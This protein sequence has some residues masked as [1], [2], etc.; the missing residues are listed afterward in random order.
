MAAAAKRADRLP[1]FFALLRDNL[2]T[3]VRAARQAAG[4]SQRELGALSNLARDYVR[5]IEAGET[6]ASL[7]TICA[8]AEHLGKHPLELLGSP[9]PES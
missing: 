9:T 6:N 5:R 2:A 8:L 4:L 1:L 3:N 7:E